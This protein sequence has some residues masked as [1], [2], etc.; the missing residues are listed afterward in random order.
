MFS[1]LPWENGL[2]EPEHDYG[3]FFDK[4]QM[5]MRRWDL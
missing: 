4:D 5:D 2:T 3:S 1:D